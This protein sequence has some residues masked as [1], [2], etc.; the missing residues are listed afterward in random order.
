MVV[1]LIAFCVLSRKGTQ[2]GPCPCVGSSGSWEQLGELGELC[3]REPAVPTAYKKQRPHKHENS[4]F[5]FKG[6]TRG[7][8]KNHDL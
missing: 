8:S 1:K 7:D 3:G 4:E 2:K 6:P 5:W